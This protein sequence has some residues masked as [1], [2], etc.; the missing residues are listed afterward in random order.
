M[1]LI[2]AKPTSLDGGLRENTVIKRGLD[3]HW[4]TVQVGAEPV[5]IK[6][7][8]MDGIIVNTQPEYEDIVNVANQSGRS[9]KTVLGDAIAAAMLEDPIR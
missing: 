9:I 5:R 6:V 2:Q 8:I 1:F 3:R 4:M 7:E